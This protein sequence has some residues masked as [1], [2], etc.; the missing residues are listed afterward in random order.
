MPHLLVQ[1]LRSIPSLCPCTG[2]ADPDPICTVVVEVLDIIAGVVFIAGS[3]C[4]LPIYSHDLHIFLIGCSLFVGG[5]SIFLCISWFTLVEAILEKGS[6]I[7]A[8]ENALY[9]AGS[10]VFLIGTFL[11]YPAEGHYGIDRI[12]SPMLFA[13]PHGHVS[14]SL[15]EAFLRE[16][17]LI[18]NDGKF[19]PFPMFF[20][21][22]MPEFMGTVL[23]IVGSVLFAAA[24][25]VNG[26][27]Q[28]SFHTVQSRM[29]TATT[30]LYMAGSLLFVMG[31]VAF[32]PEL[33]C[34]DKML[35]LGAWCYI[36]G[37][38]AYLTGSVISLLRTLRN[39]R[40]PAEAFTDEA[41]P[42]KSAKAAV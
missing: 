24:A 2:K 34:G 25:F 14:P 37:S 29:L 18:G 36:V 6:S 28:T 23:F 9:L 12:K 20:N 4:F 31:S 40:T 35:S 38:T 5:S 7:E 21:L 42:L 27:S 26:L 41:M 1:R 16:K 19:L 8:C 22:F 13:Q 3:I 11:F 32:L 39:L 15:E 17:L 30:S 10:L 33:G